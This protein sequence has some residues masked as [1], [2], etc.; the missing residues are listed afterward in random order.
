MKGKDIRTVGAELRVGSV[1]EGSVR[2]ADDQL[3]VT[4]QLI[5]VSDG[6]HLWSARYDR[7]LA[8][9][10]AVQAEVAR[11]IA[12]AVRAELG[13]EHDYSWLQDVHAPSDVRAYELVRRATD[14][15]WRLGTEAAH[16]QA[17]EYYRQALAI[18]P[19]YA[20]AHAGLGYAHL[21]LFRFYGRAEADLAMARAQGERAL[22]ADA[23]NG[24]ALSLLTEL[25]YREYRWNEARATVD[26]GLA[27]NP[28][29]SGLRFNSAVVFAQQG[30]TAE[31][32]AEMRRAV[33]LDPRWWSSHWG[34]GFALILAGEYRDAADAIERAW[35]LGGR[36]PGLRGALAYAYYRAGRNEDALEALVRERTLELEAWASAVRQGFAEAGFLGA[37][38]RDVE[39]RIA[40][41][42]D[43]CTSVDGEIVAS[44][45][46]LIGET[47]AMFTC[48]ERAF[49]RGGDTGL[50]LRAFAVWD[51]YRS[52]PRFTALLRRMNLAE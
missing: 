18:D 28:G 26:E 50:F 21:Y 36:V 45:L 3:R 48:L 6:F 8:D 17:V 25:L 14:A 20:D 4:A 12:E 47:D 41:R 44:T 52:D 1:V 46:A 9:V 13:V 16:R 22:A 27:H 42:G 34:L 29:N 30:R 35:A 32:V 43:G 37:A 2:R 11:A 33:D 5:R 10:F 38:R 49:D 31:A 23:T 7:K 51:P 40:D 39:W 19:D 24:A 15:T